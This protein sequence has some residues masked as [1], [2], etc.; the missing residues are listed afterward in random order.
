MSS[1]LFVLHSQSIVLTSP[2][3][4]DTPFRGGMKKKTW[5]K[6]EN[7]FSLDGCDYS[8]IL[9]EFFRILAPNDTY[10]W[11]W[12]KRKFWT[13]PPFAFQ[14]LL[15]NYYSKLMNMP[16]RFKNLATRP[17]SPPLSSDFSQQQQSF[18]KTT[19]QNYNSAFK[20]YK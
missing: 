13:Q 16:K 14:S 11:N 15:I 6:T 1:S 4:S 19:T 18:W 10:D 3:Y 12:K 2:P 20:S 5:I 17:I 9:G 7:S 8:R